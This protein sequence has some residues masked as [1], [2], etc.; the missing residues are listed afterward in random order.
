MSG[1]GPLQV[2]SVET[3]VGL[4]LGHPGR[5]LGV[6]LMGQPAQRLRIGA[7]DGFQQLRV[8]R[9]TSRADHLVRGGGAV[10]VV[11]EQHLVHFSLGAAR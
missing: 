6:A 7:V 5:L 9:G 11:T 3:G 2:D 1:P 8:Q 10:F 4:F